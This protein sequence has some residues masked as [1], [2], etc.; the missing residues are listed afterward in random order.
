MQEKRM[1]LFTSWHHCVC[2][3]C[4]FSSPCRCLAIDDVYRLSLINSFCICECVCFSAPYIPTR[5]NTTNTR[6]LTHKCMH[7]RGND[8]G[9]HKTID[10]YRTHRAKWWVRRTILFYNNIIM[11]DG[12]VCRSC[13]CTLKYVV[14]CIVASSWPVKFWN[15][16]AKNRHTCT[17]VAST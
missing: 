3:R 12:T 8:M 2:K 17:H 13:K 10:D 1:N 15:K 7:P 16:I 6:A 5:S 14:W 9:M 11:R 4:Y